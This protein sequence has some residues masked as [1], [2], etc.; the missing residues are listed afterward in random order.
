MLPGRGRVA[1]APVCRADDPFRVTGHRPTASMA[2]WNAIPGHRQYTGRYAGL[3]SGDIY[4]SGADIPA[5][6]RPGC[7]RRPLTGAPPRGGHTP[8]APPTERP[9]RRVL[10][11]LPRGAGRPHTDGQG[12]AR[13]PAGDPGSSLPAG[14][15]H[16]LGR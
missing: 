14:R 10:E 4:R 6:G 15:G 9:T 16:G 3:V 13:L 2:T 8:H 1:T 5:D 12:V 11:C 7:P